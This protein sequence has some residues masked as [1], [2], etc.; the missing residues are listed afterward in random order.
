LARW[1]F[2]GQQQTLRRLNRSFDGFF[3]RVKAGQAP[4]YPRFKS[5]ARFDTVDHVNGDGA[6]WAPTDG[7]WARC[8]LQGVGV[9]QV[10]EHTTVRGRVTQLSLK[11]E[12]RRWYVI[13]VATTGVEPLAKTGRSV[14]IDVGIARFLTASNGTMV[15]N[16]RF[17]RTAADDIA[18]LQQALARCKQGSGNRRRIKR[19]IA[20][21]HRKVA[22]Q[23]RDFHH[24]VARVLVN[25][26]DSIAHEALKVA[27]MVRRPKP[28][29]DG[30]GGYEPN[31]AS[32][33][34]G[35]N[36]SISDAGWGQFIGILSAKA[37]SAGR[38]VVAVNPAGTSIECHQCGARQTRPSQAVVVCPNCGGQDA[39]WNAAIN[40]YIRAGLGSDRDMAYA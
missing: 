11:R 12:G 14:G 25:N 15:A 5:R 38:N 36:R 31:G 32:A 35:L 8:Y 10:S 17:M 18:A 9:I 34:A 23:R 33:K 7:R 24:Q 21:M 26:N 28:R 30:T 16:P 1:S 29:P 4:G 27:N 6:K 37:E 22:D 13:A 39:D 2:T 20:R 40:I 3:R 19:A